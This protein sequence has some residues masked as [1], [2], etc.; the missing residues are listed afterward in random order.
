[1]T[2]NILEVKNLV[3][4]F[5][6][7]VVHRDI[8]F[9]LKTGETIGLLGNSGTGKSVLLRSL[10]G[11]EQIEGGEILFHQQR[12]D[13]LS[14]QQL[15]PIRT[16]ISYSFQNAAL[17]DSIS[18]YENIAYPLFE[19]SRLTEDE[20]KVKVRNILKT[21][22]L[23][24]A[25]DLMPSDL[26]GGMQKRVGLARSMVLSPEIM[27]YDEP[28]AGLDPVNIEM[29]LDIM[30]RFKKQGLSGILVTHDIPAAKKICDRILILKDGMIG[31]T[32]TVEEFENSKDPF[33]QSFLGQ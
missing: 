16:K 21:V 7:K 14:E 3:K 11:L 1:M 6:E 28:T 19:H 33:V 4:R 29:V 24:Q 22:N 12:I 13:H 8:S 31:F 25:I 5:D 32:G 23:E 30:N 9:F 15:Y 10:I 20:I 2:E 18:V 27:L 17:F 26:S